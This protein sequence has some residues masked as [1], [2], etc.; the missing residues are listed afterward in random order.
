RPSSD[1]IRVCARDA[2]D[3]SDVRRRAVMTAITVAQ[4][5][6][7]YLIPFG[8]FAVVW[9]ALTVAIY[10]SVRSRFAFDFKHDLQRKFEERRKL[11]SGARLRMS[12][13]YVAKLLA[14]DNCIQGAFL[15]RVS[16]FLVRHRL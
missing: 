5:L 7:L 6:V 10:I 4:L 9:L 14:G 11:P 16:R 12:Y 1:G 15:Y 13:P 2:V 3:G 8:A